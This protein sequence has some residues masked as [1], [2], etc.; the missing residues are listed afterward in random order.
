MPTEKDIL[1]AE[2][3]SKARTE[4][5]VKMYYDNKAE[6]QHEIEVR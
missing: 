5:I 2:K 4:A 3:P 1:Y 6:N